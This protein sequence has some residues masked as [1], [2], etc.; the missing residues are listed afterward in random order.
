M[1]NFKTVKPQARHK[2]GGQAMVEYALIAA[3][4]VLA[5]AVALAATGPAIGNVFSNVIYGI[6]GQAPGAPAVVLPGDSAAFWA[7]VT[8]VAANPQRETPFATPINTRERTPPT[9]YVSP[10]ASNTGT[11]TFTP[12]LTHTRT[13]THTPTD[14]TVPTSGP[15][16][17]P[18]DKGF[19]VP[20]ADRADVEMNWRLDNSFV[21]NVAG[22]TG[23]Y[24]NGATCPGTD[25]DPGIPADTTLID[26]T[27]G[28][29][30]AAGINPDNFIACWSNTFTLPS[31]TNLRFT[32]E[33]LAAGG[34][35]VAL[36]GVEIL[37]TSAAD[38]SANRMVSAGEHTLTASYAHSTGSARVYLLIDRPSQNPN[39]V[40][41]GIEGCPWAT[42]SSNI[43]SGSP[44][45]VFD[46]DPAADS[47]PAGQTCYLE[48]RGWINSSAAPNSKLSF[49]DVWDFAAAAGVRAELQIANYDA[50]DGSPDVQDRAATWG[51]AITVPLTRS[52]GSANYNWTRTQVDL[53]DPLYASIGDKWTFRFVLGNTTGSAQSLRWY[54]DDIQVLNDPAPSRTFTVRDLWDLN[55][56][57]QMA[58]FIF[59]ADANFTQEQ[60]TGAPPASEWRWNILSDN[61]R[62]G[63]AWVLK[64]YAASAASTNSSPTTDRVYFLEF[65]YPIDVTASRVPLPPVEDFEGDTGTP[66]L[67]FWHSFS[68]SATRV[69]EY[70][71]L[72]A[73]NTWI[74]ADYI[75]PL[76]PGSTIQ[77]SSVYLPTTEPFRLRFR[78]TIPQ[79]VT[80]AAT[81]GWFID[82]ILI[83]RDL[84]SGFTA[85]PFIDSAESA[86]YTAQQWTTT[87]NWTSTT[88]V[89]GVQGSGYS[90]TDSPGTGVRY[91][92][93]EETRFEMRRI[94]DL[95]GDTAG[96]TEPTT[97]AAAEPM[98]TFWM[99]RDLQGEFRVELWTAASDTWTT[100]WTMNFPGG[101]SR[102]TAW[103][104]VEINLAEAIRLNNGTSWGSIGGGSDNDD[105]IRIRFRLLGAGATAYDGIYIDDI[106]IEDKAELVHVLGA[107]DDGIYH[108][109]I[110]ANTPH[111][112]S[113]ADS[114]HLGGTWNWS[115]DPAHIYQGTLSLA[116]SPLQQYQSDWI[117]IAEM[118]PVFDL[119]GVS[120]A[121]LPSLDFFTRFEIAAGDSF[122]VEISEQQG[123]GTQSYDDLFGWSTWTPATLY[124]INMTTLT[125]GRTD[126][127]HRWRVNLSSYVNKRI[128]IRFVLRTDGAGV[129][130]GVTIDAVSL[131][132]GA[133]A[134]TSLPL[135]TWANASN[136]IF[137][138]SGLTRWGSATQFITGGTAG[139]DL[140]ANGWYGL[141]FDCETLIDPDSAC[142]GPLAATTYDGL[143][144][145]NAHD[146]FDT[147]ASLPGGITRPTTNPTADL[148]MWVADGAAPNVVGSTT[149]FVES[150]A[151]RWTRSVTLKANTT[152]RFY[153]VSDAGIRVSINS[154]AGFTPAIPAV[155]GRYYLI[156][157]WFAHDNQVD[158]RTIQVGAAD[159]NAV[160]T[161][162]FFDTV[163]DSVASLTSVSDRF[164]FS[165]SP[166]PPNVTGFTTI[167]S[168]RYGNSSLT[169]SGF[170]NATS[171][172]TL[173]YS[174]L[175]NMRSNTNLY[176]ETSTNGGFTWNIVDTISGAVTPSN[177][178]P[179]Q[180]WVTRSVPLAAGNPRT[181]FRFRLDTRGEADNITGDGVWISDIYVP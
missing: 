160:L 29:S 54:I 103:E 130:D 99:Q 128:R 135:A 117:A 97:P 23:T 126:T 108:D 116:D 71:L 64:N 55:A 91:T 123:G 149:E 31:D 172:K 76:T 56:R 4:V 138:G 60:T 136:W 173:N 148:N 86:S 145:A 109:S 52:S 168:T 73:P 95:L 101:R 2:T 98:L 156:N 57:A 48:L 12:T 164:S 38:T 85:Y 37:N 102:N 11:M 133:T 47:W 170:I 77:R 72:S 89:G 68:G 33:E 120:A 141:F 180:N 169:Y 115:N 159:V 41:A 166:N 178:L 122:Q 90:Y 106:R 129:A 7:T 143:L 6:V 142:F 124:P 175:W 9:A 45:N 81:D 104:R 146:P 53:N 161:V 58:D 22:W 165:D 93:G 171:A 137:E 94:L 75:L 158:T 132:Y 125:N 66:M 39:D 157:A 25:P 155:G 176:V 174:L 112:L 5:F 24:Y 147:A 17:T 84:G 119:S 50:V 74:T 43:L 18:E 152:Y 35:T 44:L 134:V 83:E 110:D 163:G 96:H 92:V 70:A 8:W 21:L 26:F 150:F 118:R 114:W 13:P 100:A 30:P 154:P 167:L 131:T 67:T 34:L 20:F 113:I 179:A 162:E 46:D 140:G 107:G 49:W 177:V 3:F 87:K 14:T 127:M 82:D 27:W 144:A 59:N 15:S 61:A 151:A 79:N 65:R 10:T 181:T 121:E 36:D 105:D 63:T 16:P 51:D 1:D 78:L 139:G 62:T 32:A 80:P 153:T 42:T 88:L 40:V 111:G 69:V 28:G 19:N